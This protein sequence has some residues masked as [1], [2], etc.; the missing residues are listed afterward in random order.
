LKVVQTVVSDELHK[1]LVEIS[2]KE[3][4]PIKQLVR[5]ALEEWITWRSDII[6]DSFL[7]LEP[8][9][10]GVKTNSSKLEKILYGEAKK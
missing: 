2:K 3:G 8:V 9:D 7:N 4:K 10:F 5:E 6:D 1:K